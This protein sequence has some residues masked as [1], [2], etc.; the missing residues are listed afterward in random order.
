MRRLFTLLSALSL[1]LFAATVVL[2]VRSYWKGDTIYHITKG[3]YCHTQAWSSYGKIDIARERASRA[4]QIMPSGEE[5]WKWG[6]FE[7]Y[8]YLEAFAPE[9]YFFPPDGGDQQSRV[10]VWC[11]LEWWHKAIATDSSDTLTVPY[12][13]P[14][15]ALALL[16]LAWASRRLLA[17]IR[18]RARNGLCPTCGY[19]LRATPDRCPECGAVPKKVTA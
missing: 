19:D 15:S 2:W 8:P 5:G 16:P 3:H 11:G 6:G 12:A 10:W 7:L 17:M 14:V 13:Y 4:G 18:A 9:T 1:V